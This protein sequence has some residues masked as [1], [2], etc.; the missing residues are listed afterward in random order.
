MA[1]IRITVDGRLALTTAQAA[2]RH[3]RSRAAMRM[4]LARLDL[5]PVAQLDDRTPLYAA[6]P[7]D[8]AIKALPGRGANLRG[9]G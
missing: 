3:D 4:L 5:E 7:L 2:T 8:K 6:A 1:Q 9:H